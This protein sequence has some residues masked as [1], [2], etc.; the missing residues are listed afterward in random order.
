M[1]NFQVNPLNSRANIN[2]NYDESRRL[3]FNAHWPNVNGLGGSIV[4][5]GFTAPHLHISDQALCLHKHAN[6]DDSITESY[7]SKSL[8]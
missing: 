6:Y 1:I 5:T 8:V 7:C 2:L 3:A 4:T